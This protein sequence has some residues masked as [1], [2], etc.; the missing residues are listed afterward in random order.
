MPGPARWFLLLYN[1][2]IRQLV[3]W[4]RGIIERL[5]D[6]VND[7]KKGNEKCGG[8]SV[9]VQPP[10]CTKCSL[11]WQNRVSGRDLGGALHSLTCILRL[12]SEASHLVR[13]KQVVYNAK[14]Q[15]VVQQP[16]GRAQ[17]TCAT[18]E[19]SEG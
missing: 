14:L 17:D 12:I 15:Q 10:G 1:V 3:V 7:K 13:Q 8:Q 19:A 6:M 5:E 11:S 9:E 4:H 2:Q 18:L 16:W